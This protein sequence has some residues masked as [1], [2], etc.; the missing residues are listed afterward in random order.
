MFLDERGGVDGRTVV[1][2]FG[3]LEPGDYLDIVGRGDE[4]E[5][6]RPAHAAPGETAGSV[7]DCDG[8]TYAGV[9]GQRF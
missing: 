2:K 8:V 9:L 3:A 5:F 4:A 6:I 7:S 1:L